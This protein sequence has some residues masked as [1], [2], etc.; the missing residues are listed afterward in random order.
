MGVHIDTNVLESD[1]G[2]QMLTATLTADVDVPTDSSPSDGVGEDAAVVSKNPDDGEYSSIQGAVDD[3]DG[4]TVYV[5]PGTYEESVEVDVEGLTLRGTTDPESGDAAIVVGQNSDTITV[6]SNDVTVER[7]NIQNPEGS[8]SGPDDNA[9]ALGVNVESGNTGVSVISNVITEIGTEN[10]DANPMAVYAQGATDQITVES[11]TITDLEGTDEDQ[12]AL[13]AVHINSQRSLGSID[14]GI[15]GARIA[16]NSITDLLDTRS[17]VAVRF[18]GDVSGEIVGNTISDLN[19]EGDIPGTNDPGGFTQVLALSEGGNSTTGPTDV[20]IENN[21]IS[22]VETTT[23]GNFAPPTHLIVTESASNVSVTGNSF[24]ADSPDVEVFVQD[25]SE[26]LDL[27]SVDQNNTFTPS[28]QKSGRALYPG[29]ITLV[30]GGGDAL[31]TAIDDASD[32]DTLAVDGSTY[33]AV[34]V[35]KS[36]DIQSI[37]ARPTID[38]TADRIEVSASDV[39]L[40]GFDIDLS[41]GE[42]VYVNPGEGL[43]FRNNTVELSRSSPHGIRIDD[44]GTAET[45]VSN[46]EF[47]LSS[48]ERD[49]PQAI[50]FSDGSNY[51][52]TNNILD[53]GTKGQAILVSTQGSETKEFD[54]ERLC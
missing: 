50:L 28:V 16:N 23:S 4:T 51:T 17:A 6:Q 22:N 12:G 29:D 20:T 46:N 44:A 10:D 47:T 5:E 49:D 54:I 32:G 42:V 14:E 24:S 41:N 31:Q 45:V 36:L 15:D 37:F 53:G 8:P 1:D 26:T 52:V 19:T 39:L 18:N 2:D 7:L 13:Q 11:N 40:S 9:G 3:V 25:A 30:T 27:T 48:S 34:S 21:D 33:N 43:V 38:A 35:D